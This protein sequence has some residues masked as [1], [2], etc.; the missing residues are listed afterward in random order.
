MSY[1]L[2]L[3]SFAR[4]VLAWLSCGALAAEVAA[5]ANAT[6]AGGGG[7]VGASGDDGDGIEEYDS[8]SKELVNLRVRC[9]VHSKKVLWHMYITDK[10][11]GIRIIL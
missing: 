8:C 2:I 10:D 7:A 6:E 9:R 3:V 4:F 11:P 1:V 5:A